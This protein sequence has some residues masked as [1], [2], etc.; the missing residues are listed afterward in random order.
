MNDEA[1]I[2]LCRDSIARGSKTFTFAS[3]FFGAEKARDAALLYHWCRNCD[4][5]VDDS[6]GESRTLGLARIK[7]EVD[8]AIGGQA[9]ESVPARALAYLVAK[10]DI[11]AHYPRELIEGMTMDAQFETP[12]SIGE[13]ELYCYRVA[14][15][16]GLMMAHILGVSSEFALRSACDLGIAMQLTNISR[17]V[18]ADHALGRCY[19]PESVLARHGLTAA[20]YAE[21]ARR[22]KLNMA[23]KELL[24][25]ADGYYASGEY[26][27]RFLSKRSSFVI[28]IA[29]FA[30]AR[31][32]AK[33]R[34][35]GCVERQVTSR[36]EKILCLFKAALT[37]CRQ[38][39]TRPRWRPATIQQVW[40]LP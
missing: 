35:R 26:G 8:R 13:L 25:L 38:Y 5:T 16:V 1:L 23:I 19:I 18:L 36:S 24:V 37:W 7:E 20:N 31:I 34:A 6:T 17:D 32:G 28:L 40:R 39:F 14:G 15:V 22:D 30:Y 10:Y 4:D 2:R 29:R 33:V 27:A 3:R 9:G 12:K 21:P 11:P